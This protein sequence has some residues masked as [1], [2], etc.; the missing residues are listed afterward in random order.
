MDVENFT[1]EEIH[2]T[3]IKLHQ[4]GFSLRQIAQRL[5]IGVNKVRYWLRVWNNQHRITKKKT[6]PTKNSF[7]E[8]LIN[9]IETVTTVVFY[10]NKKCTLLDA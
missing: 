4:D 8:D 9:Y 2:F 5:E 6:G 10:L 3:I 7:S 1:D